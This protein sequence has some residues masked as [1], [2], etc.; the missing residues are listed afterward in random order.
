MGIF[1]LRPSST[2]AGADV[3]SGTKV[4]VLLNIAAQ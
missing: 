3:N 2:V 1:R 4:S